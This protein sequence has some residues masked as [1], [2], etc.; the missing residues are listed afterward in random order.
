MNG[1]NGSARHEEEMEDQLSE[2]KEIEPK[3]EE[4]ADDA[5]MG[6]P[7]CT[8]AEECTGNST[9]QL[10]RHLLQEDDPGDV[11]CEACWA[12]YVDEN[13]DLMGVWE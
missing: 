3:A 5:D 8:S 10:V 2:P 1:T 12:G 6:H 13:P 4:D 7:E 11:Y 9:L